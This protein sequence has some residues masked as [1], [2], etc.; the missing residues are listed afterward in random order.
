MLPSE[1]RAPSTS[2]PRE[3]EPLSIAYLTYRG[4]PHVGGQG[5]YTRHLT[6]ALV[7]LGHHVEVLGGPAVPRPRRP[8][9][10]ARAAQPRH[11]QRLLPDADAGPVG[12]QALGDWVEVTAFS[13]GTFPEPL[14]FSVRAAQTCARRVNEFDLVQDNQCLGYGLLAMQRMGL[15]GARHHPPPHH[16]RPPPRD[17]A[18]RDRVQALMPRPAGTPSP[19]MQTRVARRMTRVITVSENSFDDISHRPQGR[20]RTACTS[21]PSASTRS[22]SGRCPASRASP[23]ASSPPP[24]ADVAMK[25]LA[26]LLEALAKLRTERDGLTWSSSAARRRAARPARTIDELGLADR[27]EFVT[28]VPERAHHRAVLRGRAGR[29]AVAL[30]G[31]LAAGHRGHVLRRARSWPPPAAPCPRS[32]APTTRPPCWCRPGDTEALAAK[33]RAP[34][35]TTPRC[36]P[37]SA[38]PA[39]SG[40][41]TAGPGATPP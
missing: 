27:V 20:P 7:D 26:Y 25:G 17:G 29:R 33:H 12:A 19:S 5:V 36:G 2:G 24:R 16:R 6:K 21:C 35:S 32:S 1:S 8:G 39:A 28:G 40:S 22:C 4:K 13:T 31:L 34:P 11:L 23:A 9:A 14:A 3:D 18:R 37:A 30:R 15:P 10:A 41:S 38:P